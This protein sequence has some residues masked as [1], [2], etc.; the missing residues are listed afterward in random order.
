MLNINRV[1]YIL[2]IPICPRVTQRR[3]TSASTYI[4]FLFLLTRPSVLFNDI[5]V[6]SVSPIRL[7]YLLV[8][9][10]SFKFQVEV[11]H[12]SVGRRQKFHRDKAHGHI[13]WGRSEANIQTHPRI[14]S[15]LLK[16]LSLYPRP[17]MELE[18]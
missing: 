13:R 14:A 12:T 6:A 15:D 18:Y 1:K 11:D 5:R 17:K 7:G 2:I 3:S 9:S 8:F 16:T 4:V 10:Q